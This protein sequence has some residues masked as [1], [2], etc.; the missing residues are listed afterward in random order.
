MLKGEKDNIF[1]KCRNGN[2][3]STIPRSQMIKTD[4]P[5][6]LAFYEKNLT[7]R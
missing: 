2:V 1:F 7:I 5:A 3:I 4:L 6:L